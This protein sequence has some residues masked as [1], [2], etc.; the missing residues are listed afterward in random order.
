[1]DPK[2]VARL[3]KQ[4]TQKFPEMAGARPSVRRDPSAKKGEERFLLTF[5]GKAVLPGGRTMRRIVRV[6]A[7]AHG[8][9]LKMSTSK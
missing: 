6:V 9:V 1:M 2:T 3:S 7:D 5:K 8:H 4:V